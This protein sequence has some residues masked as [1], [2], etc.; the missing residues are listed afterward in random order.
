MLS[1]S[2]QRDLL[3]AVVAEVVGDAAQAEWLTPSRDWIAHMRLRGKNG[4][5]AYILTSAEWHE[6]RFEE[7]R[8]STFLPA[9]RDDLDYLRATLQ[10]LAGVVAAYVIGAHEIEHHR[11]VLGNRTVLLVH[12]ADG[13]WRIG[14]RSTR[15]PRS[16]D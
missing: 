6:A 3:E 5:T 16:P 7:P 14:K 8:Y 15:P 11:G 12:S 2:D 10:R 13:L 1:D 9:D 4:L